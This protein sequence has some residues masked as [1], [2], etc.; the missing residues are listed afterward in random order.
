MKMK[1]HWHLYVALALM[2]L[3]L[4]GCL[5]G[6]NSGNFQDTNRGGNG[7]QIGINDQ[8]SFKGKLYFTMNHDLYRLSMQAGKQNLVKLTSNI[9]V[10]DPAVSP[11]GRKIAFVRRDKNYADLMLMDANGNNK[12]VLRSGKGRYIPNNPYPP[13]STDRWYAQPSWS[14]DG[15]NL[16]F[17]SDLGKSD[18]YGNAH[19]HPGPDTFMLDLLAYKISLDNPNVTWPQAIAYGTL[20]DGGLRDITYR[21]HHP[22]QIIYTNYSYDSTQTRQLIQLMLAD[23]DAISKYPDAYAPGDPKFGSADDPGVALTPETPDLANMQP[24]FSPDGMNIM[25]TRRESATLRS[26]Y[27]MPVAENITGVPRFNRHLTNNQAFQA[28]QQKALAPYNQSL[29]LLSKSLLTN[30]IWSPDGT[31]IAYVDNTNNTFDLWL[32]TLVKDPKTGVYSLKQ[33]STIR[34]TNAQGNFDA[35][36]RPFWTS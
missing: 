26:I 14:E 29:K 24:A 15:K 6:D 22:N 30:P 5:G 35:E 36:S 28:N 16:I 34:V 27:L 19:I 4:Q 18:A 23:P 11:D 32:T 2:T 31:Q 1:Q 7:Q 10:R 20:G 9:D 25:Y 17:L 21:P 12:H 3:L 13:I 8:V 33:D